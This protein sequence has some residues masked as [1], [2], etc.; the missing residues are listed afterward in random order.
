MRQSWET[1]FL[2][3]ILFYRTFY[4]TKLDKVLKK[5][6]FWHCFKWI[7]PTPFAHVMEFLK[8]YYII[9]T[10]EHAAIIWNSF[11][12]KNSFLS[13]ILC[14]TNIKSVKK[15]VF[16]ALFFMNLAHPH[17][18]PKIFFAH[19]TCIPMGSIDIVIVQPLETMFTRLNNQ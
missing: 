4:A 9:M 8:S 6:H 1:V 18:L 13:Y 12:A 11:P 19:K 3:K 15:V 16:L 14:K 17:T 5:L 10:L 2:P 7:W